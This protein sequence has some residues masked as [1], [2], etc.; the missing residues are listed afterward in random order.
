MTSRI[1]DGFSR[2]LDLVYPGVCELCSIVVPRGR[3]LCPSCAE[4]IPSLEPPFCSSCGESFDGE[5]HD[6][7]ECP[8]CRDVKYAFEFARPA[9][10]RSEPAMSL[11]GGLKYGKRLHLARDIADLTL[12]AFVD[13]RLAEAKEQ[14]W[15]LVPVPLH[16]RRYRWRQFNQAREIALPLGKSLGHPVLNLLK[17]TRATPT[18]TRLTRS[19][20]Q[21]NLRGAFIAKPNE[22]PGVILIDDVFTTGSTVHECARMLRKAGTGKVVVVTVLRG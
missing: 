15:P 10:I 1:L 22:Y 21:K 8:N 12:R 7:F 2:V 5:I 17:R 18:Q 13:P 11:I 6:T 14:R 4:N 9:L 16:R 19:Q 20:R 3:C